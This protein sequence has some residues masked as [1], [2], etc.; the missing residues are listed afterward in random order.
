MRARFSEHQQQSAPAQAMRPPALGGSAANVLVRLQQQLQHQE[1]QQQQSRRALPPTHQALASRLAAAAQRQQRQQ[2][3][4]RRSGSSAGGV[5]DI[6]LV[7]AELGLPDKLASVLASAAAKGQISGHP[8][9]LMAQVCARVVAAACVRVGCV[10]HFSGD[11]RLAPQPPC[12]S[13]DCCP[14]SPT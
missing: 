5:R 6:Q 8:G 11:S 14:W 2:Q 1:Q 3:H 9:T 13:S 12:S 10:L 7:C 4:K